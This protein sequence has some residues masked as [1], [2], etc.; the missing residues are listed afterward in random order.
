MT[1]TPEP[2]MSSNKY[3]DALKHPTPQVG[4]SA[5]EVKDQ[6]V[7][8]I[9]LN[10]LLSASGSDGLAVAEGQGRLEEK[11]GFCERLGGLV[12]PLPMS[13]VKYFL[14]RAGGMCGK[15]GW[16]LQLALAVG[17]A[18]SS[19]LRHR[20]KAETATTQRGA[21]LLAEIGATYS[22]ESRTGDREQQPKG[23]CERGGEGTGPSLPI[24]LWPNTVMMW[25]RDAAAKWVGLE[26]HCASH[27]QRVTKRLV[28][29]LP[30]KVNWV[31]SPAGSLPDFHMWEMCQTIPLV[32]SFFQNLVSLTLS[33]QRCSIHQSPSSSLKISLFS[34]PVATLAPSTFHSMI[35]KFL[36]GIICDFAVAYLDDVVVGLETWGGPPAPP[37]YCFG[38][39]CN[40]WP[41]LCQSQV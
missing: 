27:S 28:C 3:I 13:P 32:G 20:L 22:G 33:F 34:R 31:Q 23:S 11:L 17:V 16:L 15:A 8:V 39:A 21:G 24:H 29:S 12:L 7:D 41:D 9:N 40:Q 1:A 19:S 4:T 2:G 35:V 26:P 6:T 14:K 10:L 38:R 5:V 18:V 30:T 25:F 37:S 36:D